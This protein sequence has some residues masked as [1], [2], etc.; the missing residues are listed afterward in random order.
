M[1]AGVHASGRPGSARSCCLA[2]R[3]PAASGSTSGR[4]VMSGARSSCWPPT[5]CRGSRP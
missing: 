5:S 3:R 1:E 4:W 2:T